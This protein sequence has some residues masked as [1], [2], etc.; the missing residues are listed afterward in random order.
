[1]AVSAWLGSAGCA[2]RSVVRPLRPVYSA[3]PKSNETAGSSIKQRPPNV[4]GEP[5]MPDTIAPYRA[6]Q[7]GSLLRTAPLKEARAKRAKGEIA[8]AQL[9]AVEDEEIRKLVRKQE[10][11]GLKLA[12]DGEFR[13]TFWQLDFFGGLD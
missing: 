4:P 13:R 2:P 11:V 1:M 10:E 7:V 3:R 12:T 5:P 6:D 8:P 9:K